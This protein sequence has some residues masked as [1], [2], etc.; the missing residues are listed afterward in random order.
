M[1]NA[2][3]L[4]AKVELLRVSKFKDWKAIKQMGLIIG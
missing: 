1:I 2:Y 4:G 3:F